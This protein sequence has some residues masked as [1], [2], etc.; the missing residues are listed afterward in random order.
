MNNLGNDFSFSQFPVDFKLSQCKFEPINQDYEIGVQEFL[1]KNKG[2]KR[3]LKKNYKKFSI[4]CPDSHQI[5]NILKN[6]EKMDLSK[7]FISYSDLVG[8]CWGYR[9]AVILSKTDL[10]NKKV[11]LNHV[12]KCIWDIS[13]TFLLLTEK[14]NQSYSF[15]QTPDK[16]N[17]EVNHPLD[18]TGPSRLI[19]V[20]HENETS[21]DPAQM[22]AN[23]KTAGGAKGKTKKA[24]KPKNRT[25]VKRTSTAGRKRKSTS[26]K[27]IQMPKK[28]N[29]AP[30]PTSIANI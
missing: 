4:F 11:L 29:T 2:L 27:N 18:K 23:L 13:V 26:T 22:L 9:K 19:E 16:N 17:M 6:L 30:K 14:Q 3:E 15:H 21:L 10:E 25:R 5:I 1:N 7:T 24:I 28:V 12:N 20:S 8:S